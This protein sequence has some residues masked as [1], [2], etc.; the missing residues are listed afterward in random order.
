MSLASSAAIAPMKSTAR[1]AGHF[2]LSPLWR[3]ESTIPSMERKVLQGHDGN[4]RVLSM[5]VQRPLYGL[6]SLPALDTDPTKF[7][8]IQL[9][10]SHTTI[11]PPYEDA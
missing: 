11:E 8:I 3:T 9:H 6:E 5:S 1:P 10:G 2:T 4:P 7:A